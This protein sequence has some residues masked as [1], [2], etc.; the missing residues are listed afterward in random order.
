MAV[1]AVDAIVAHVVLMAE[2]N[3]LRAS[4]PDAGDVGGPVDRCQGGHD[5]EK[6]RDASKDAH[7]GDR[8]R[9]WVKDLSHQAFS[10]S[11][12]TSHLSSIALP[13]G[14]LSL[15][16]PPRLPRDLSMNSDSWKRLQRRLT[17][18]IASKANAETLSKR[19][20]VPSRLSCASCHATG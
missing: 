2:R 1:P 13:E 3:R 19:P 6:K 14:S 20:A 5:S 10:L 7:S 8:V 12:E 9:A 4:D 18:I 15:H 16:N 11:S 17:V